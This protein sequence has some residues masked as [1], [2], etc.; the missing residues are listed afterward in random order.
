MPKKFLTKS[1]QK[2]KFASI[3]DDDDVMKH[4]MTVLNIFSN[5]IG[6]YFE[7][8]IY[9]IVIIF[10]FCNNEGISYQ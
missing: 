7:V 8:R 4:T 9:L 2:Q 3:Q 6:Q 10:N 1:K 5:Q